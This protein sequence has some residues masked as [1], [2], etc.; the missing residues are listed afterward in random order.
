MFFLD[1]AI[2]SARLSVTADYSVARDFGIVISRKDI[3]HR[4]ICL[5][6]P[7]LPAHLFIRQGFAFGNF[8]HYNK[9]F[10]FKIFQ[11]GGGGI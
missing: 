10:L 3:P 11:N 9:N 7:R 1:P 2:I 6:P 4:A 5:R 8:G